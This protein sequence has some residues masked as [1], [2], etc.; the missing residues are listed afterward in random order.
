MVRIGCPG[1]TVT[2]VSLIAPSRP[3]L[4]YP[5]CEQLQE[6][7]GTTC[8]YNVVL[9]IR[10]ARMLSLSRGKQIYL[11]PARRKCTRVLPSHAE[12]DQLSDIAEIKTDPASV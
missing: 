12:Q 11:P 10:L 8:L 7:P 6:R 4:P 3:T 9:L 5:S 2:L 1:R